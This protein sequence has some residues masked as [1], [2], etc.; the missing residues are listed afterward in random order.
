MTKHTS[1]AALAARAIRKEFKEAGIR[2]D[3]VT[4]QNFAGGNS[5]RVTFTDAP[6]ETRLKAHSIVQKYQYGYFDGS[7]DLYIYNPAE[8][9][10]PQVKYTNVQCNLS[11]ELQQELEAYAAKHFN[12]YDPDR[13]AREF[14]HRLYQAEMQGF[15]NFWT[16]RASSPETQTSAK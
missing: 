16:D 13:N 8:K 1:I 5:V 3:R 6:P 7:Q 4:S 15:Q 9:T 11:P 2:P 14:V 10:L 12:D